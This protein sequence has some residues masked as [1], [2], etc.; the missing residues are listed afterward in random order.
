MTAVQAAQYYAFWN[1][2]QI[3]GLVPGLKGAAEY[4]TMM[5]DNGMRYTDA[6][7]RGMDVQSIEHLLI[8]AFIVVGNVGFFAERARQKREAAERSAKS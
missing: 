3:I 8:I 1:A 6:P 4:Q 5:K 2:R 7:L